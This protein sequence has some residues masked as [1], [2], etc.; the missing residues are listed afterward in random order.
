MNEGVSFSA[1][2]LLYEYIYK[3]YVRDAIPYHAHNKIQ[4]IRTSRGP[5]PNP[6]L[7]QDYVVLSSISVKC[8]SSCGKVPF[9]SL[10]LFSFFP[11]SWTRRSDR[12]S[13]VLATTTLSVLVQ[14]FF[15]SYWSKKESCCPRRH[16]STQHPWQLVTKKEEEHGSQSNTTGNN[17][18]ILGSVCVSCDDSSR[19]TGGVDDGSFGIRIG[20][21]DSPSFATSRV[22]GIPGI[23]YCSTGQLSCE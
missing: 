7:R 19:R 8:T 22:N 13:T 1:V 9:S 6:N 17:H 10:S 11:S 14:L 5:Y 18:G 23:P 15:N 2:Y 16:L 21:R 4:I 12:V 3:E 20:T